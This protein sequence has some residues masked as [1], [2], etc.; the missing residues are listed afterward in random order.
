MYVRLEIRIDP[1]RRIHIAQRR[2]LINSA[3]GLRGPNL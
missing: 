1:P 2:A 3:D